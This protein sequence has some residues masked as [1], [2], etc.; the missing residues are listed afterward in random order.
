MKHTTFARISFIIALML[1]LVPALVPVLA[2]ADTA[3]TLGASAN[4]NTTVTTPV[5]GASASAGANV[6]VSATVTKGIQR[7][8]QEIDRRVTNLN[9]LIARVGQM[10]NLSDTDKASIAGTLNAQVTALGQLKTK[11]DADA[12]ATTLKADVKSI[13]D[14]YRIYALIIPQGAIIAAA[15]RVVTVSTTLHLIAAKLTSRIQSAQGA[16]A[17]VTAANTLF[18]DYNAKVADAQVQAQS[19]VTAIVPLTP[20]NGDTKI[21]ASNASTL[22]AA[23]AKIQAAQQDLVTARQDATKILAE[24]QKIEAS[25]SASASA[26]TSAS[27]G[28]AQ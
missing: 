15:D 1:G 22:K 27:T 9:A 5:A 11:I 20:D 3:T 18:A 12:D 8:D 24:F 28:A 19:A 26:T 10:K 23:H 13:T 2:S 16:G 21:A 6:Q 17:D 25:G 7:G 4:A 14:S